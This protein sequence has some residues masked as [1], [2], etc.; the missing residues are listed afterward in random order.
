V[1]GAAG[2]DGAGDDGFE[3]SDDVEGAGGDDPLSA[4]EEPDSDF[5]VSGFDSDLD[6]LAVPESGVVED[7]EPDERLSVL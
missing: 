5:D 3:L 6:S 7:L 1:A 2:L 4:P